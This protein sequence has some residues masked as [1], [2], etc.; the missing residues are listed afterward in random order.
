MIQ[1]FE[2]FVPIMVDILEIF[3]NFVNTK[4]D[5]AMSQEINKIFSRRLKQAR[6]MKGISLES[7][8]GMMQNAVTRQA[9]N[10]YE[11]GKM[12]PDSTVLL[13]L[14]SALGVK[15]DFFFRPFSVEVGQV[16]FRKKAK[17][18]AVKTEALKERVQEEL[19]RYLEIEQMSGNEN[20]FLVHKEAVSTIDDAR[21]VAS[22]VRKKFSLGIDGISN[23]IEVLEDN[24][25]KVIEVEESDAFDGLCGYVNGNIPIIV[26]NAN[27][28]AERKRFTALHE[29][30]HLLME[31]PENI[32]KKESEAL[33][34]AFANEMLIPFS[35]LEKKIGSKRHDISLN[36]LTDIQTQFGISVDAL[37]YILHQRG[38]I[39]D[40]R[41]KTFNIKKNTM[42]VFKSEVQKSRIPNEKSGRFFRMVYRALADEI[43]SISKAAALLNTSVDKVQAQLQLV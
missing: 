5:R 10:K 9:I 17:F 32:E 24:G 6:K 4:T 30:G 18:S 38:V 1:D 28:P 15:I 19:E 23:V 29:L 37:M 7:L 26:I 27:F 14:A 33:C 21:R 43:I 11:Q 36:E 25:I 3:S 34:N 22:E 42:E 31:M 13:A 35:V 41:Y 40:N 39:S 12:M 20:R 2:L 8:S 16:D